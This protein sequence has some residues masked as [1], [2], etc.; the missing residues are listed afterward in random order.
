M[1][2]IGY[3]GASL[4]DFIAT[5][6]AASVTMLLDVRELPISR[7]KGFSKRALSD[8]LEAEGISYRH[9]RD[10]GSPKAIRHQLHEDHD[11]DQFFGAF[12]TY[13]KSQRPLLKKLAAELDGRVA[14]MCFERDPATCHRSI[15]AKQL[16]TLTQLKTKHLGVM[17]GAASEGARA[18]IG[19]GVPTA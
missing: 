6:K 13:L 19:E 8:A 5:L 10:L 15:V 16:E 2:T 3:E 17:H 4:E 14:L 1:L 7:R 11:Y 9:E 18:G 12:T